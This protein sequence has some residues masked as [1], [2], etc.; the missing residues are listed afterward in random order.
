MKLT[1][2]T[3]EESTFGNDRIRIQGEVVFEHRSER[4]RLWFDFPAEY[5]GSLSLSGNPWLACLLPLAVKMGEPLQIS[6]CVDPLLLENAKGLMQIWR[7]WYP[8]LHIVPIEAGPSEPIVHGTDGRVAA[9]FSGGIDSY[10]TVLRRQDT[11]F[12]SPV[13]DLLLVWGFDIQLHRREEFE[14]LRATIEASADALGKR[15]IVVATNIKEALFKDSS[16]A[17]LSHGCAL[18]SVGLALEGRF[19]E[20]LIASSHSY[21]ALQPWGSHPLTDPLLST[22]RT[23]IVHDGTSFSRAEKTELVAKSET[24]MRSLRVC[25]MSRSDENCSTCNKCYRTMA[26]LEVLGALDGCKTF[27]K[28]HF[29]LATLGKIYSEDDNARGFFRE[30]RDFARR[31]EREDI[32]SSIERSLAHSRRLEPWLRI[33]R[34]LGHQRFVWR[35]EAPLRRFILR[36][37]VE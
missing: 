16:W 25:G 14:R 1:K 11:T 21:D 13:D 2:S 12:P 31:R 3:I 10:F 18:A 8:S 9:F 28:D 32:A 6:P 23:R 22:T 17:Y 24:A 34:W 33:P 29:S 19:R 4:E 27:R 20:V 5:E 30:V 36:N 37:S 15:A 35:L 7:S 26:T